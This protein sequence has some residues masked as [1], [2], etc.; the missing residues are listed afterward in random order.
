MTL[1]EILIAAGL[2]VAFFGVYVAIARLDSAGIEEEEETEPKA[3]RLAASVVAVAL[4]AAG[5]WRRA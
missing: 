4:W 3:S 5:V 2:L 1:P